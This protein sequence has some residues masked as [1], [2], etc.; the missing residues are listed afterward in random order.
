MAKPKKNQGWIKIHR[1]LRDH[2]VYEDPVSTW[3]WLEILFRANHEGKTI[4]IGTRTIDIKPG[5]FWTSYRKL[6]IAWN[7]SKDT[8]KSRL[9]AFE[10]DKMIKVDG[11]PGTGTLVTVCNY[12]V[13][14]SSKGVL[15]D[16]FKDRNQD[17]NQDNGS[18]IT[19]TDFSYKQELKNDKEGY[20]NEKNNG[21]PPDDPDYFEEV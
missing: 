16:T 13:Y 14:Q 2:W 19:R 4:H 11:K 21:L 17:R 15:P 5:Q 10:N 6:S 12:G 1:S 20:K 18:T 9:R 7:V 8:V 3:T